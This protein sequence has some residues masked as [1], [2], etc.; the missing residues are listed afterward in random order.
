MPV[1]GPR[2]QPTAEQKAVAQGSV[3]PGLRAASSTA[4][5]S[6]VA[7]AALQKRLARI[8]HARDLLLALLPALLGA[9]L[10]YLWWACGHSALPASARDLALPGVTH[11]RS[12]AMA[13]LGL[14]GAGDASGGDSEFGGVPSFSAQDAAST[15]PAAGGLDGA[16]ASAW[17]VRLP[18][19]WAEPVCSSDS[20]PVPL[21]LL[22]L[23]ASR[24][25][26]AWLAGAL[27][28]FVSGK[29]GDSSAARGPGS[30]LSALLGGA[31]G[32]APGLLG[33]ALKYGPKALSAG[34]A[35]QA[36]AGDAAGFIVAFV[37]VA[38]LLPQGVGIGRAA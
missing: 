21:V 25:L 2:P 16:S 30:D 11:V 17:L 15:S 37:L 35:L 1:P 26:V 32:G 14:G 38:A 28:T 36:A 24:Q 22:L 20:W 8:S 33:T 9:A 12:L 29:P 31:G 27:S 18:P 10:S 23:I 5:T 6:L 13:K 19:A 3:P 34:R 4:S 7:A